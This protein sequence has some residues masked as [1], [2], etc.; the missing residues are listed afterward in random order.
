MFYF[1]VVEFKNS[2]DA[3][4]AIKEVDGTEWLGRTLHCREVILF[5]WVPCVN[6]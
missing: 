3:L 4:R 5:Q 1:S 6:E 2:D